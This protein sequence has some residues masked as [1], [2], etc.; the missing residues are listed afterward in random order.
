MDDDSKAH[1]IL[2]LLKYFWLILA[3][4]QSCSDDAGYHRTCRDGQ[5]VTNRIDARTR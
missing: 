4:T 1:R 3:D 2:H 5:T